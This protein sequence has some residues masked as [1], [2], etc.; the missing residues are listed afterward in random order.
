MA[1][2]GAGYSTDAGASEG[3]EQE[4]TQV[5]I[6]LGEDAEQVQGGLEGLLEKGWVLDGEGMGIKKTF[7]FRSYFKAVVG[8]YCLL[9]FARDLGRL[10]DCLV[11]SFVNVVASQSA[12]KKHH[13]TM[14]VV[15][16]LFLLNREKLAIC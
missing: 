6:S 8:F 12:I 7:H 2:S 1:G 3:Q 11:Q 4:Q 14:T 9:F 15:S 5:Q 13:P 16:F 10:I